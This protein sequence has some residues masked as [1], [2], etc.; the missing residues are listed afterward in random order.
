MKHLISIAIVAGSLFFVSPAL[1]NGETVEEKKASE[2]VA[3][4]ESFAGS[5][6]WGISIE[7]TGDG[8][9]IPWSYYNGTKTAYS[10]AKTAVA[11][12]PE[13]E[14]KEE[15]TKRLNEKVLVLINTDVTSIGRAVAYIDAINA[16]NKMDQARKV[17]Q[18]Q[19]DQNLLND[20]TI[21]LYH[22]LSKEIRKQAYLLDRVYGKSTRDMIRGNF[23]GQAEQLKNTAMYPV[24]LKTNLDELAELVEL[25]DY[26]RAA[27]LYND[28]AKVFKN[29]VE[30]GYLQVNEAPES[31]YKQ[32]ETKLTALGKNM[33]VII[34]FTLADYETKVNY[35]QL[36]NG[37]ETSK[38]PK[39]V[40]DA[41]DEFMV[42]F[43]IPYT[44][45]KVNIVAG[46]KNEVVYTGTD[47]KDVYISL[48]EA[49]NKLGVT[50]LGPVTFVITLTTED[51]TETVYR[52]TYEVQ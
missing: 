33:P 30:S 26:S 15:L 11:K 20:Q 44:N 35:T 36:Y 16:G 41:A 38:L 19:F 40:L 42:R 37:V 23:K 48:I 12:L 24:T 8:K 18:K 43:Y 2:L 28:T 47:V 34:D 3:K 29:G 13:G 21:A 9:T 51:Q 32:L 7:G 50:E 39:A 27:V 14:V 52:K 49:K 17:L 22:G 1:A 6:K 4:A 5:L 10:K 46:D 45:V 25:T 31:I